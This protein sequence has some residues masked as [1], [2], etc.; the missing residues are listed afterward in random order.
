[1]I[2]LFTDFVKLADMALPPR[3]QRHHYF[4]FE[5]LEYTD[6]DITD[7]EDR[8]AWKSFYMTYP[9]FWIRRIDCLYNLLFLLTVGYPR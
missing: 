7:F 5:G 4:S 8:L 3:D 6:A 9:G 1:M 2:N